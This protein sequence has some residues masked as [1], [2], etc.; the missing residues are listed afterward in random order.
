MILE[1]EG[2]ACE[3]WRDGPDWNGTP[4]AAIGKLRI[5]DRASGTA[6][7]EKAVHHLHAAG[8]TAILAPMDGD[9][10]HPYRSVTTSDGSPPLFCSSPCPARTMPPRSLPPGFRLSPTTSP[11][12]HPCTRPA[13][14]LRSFPASR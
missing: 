13:R 12:V 4:A 6:L 7:L 9:T 1:H 11:A 2:A 3:V 14:P 10:W 8:R 5:P